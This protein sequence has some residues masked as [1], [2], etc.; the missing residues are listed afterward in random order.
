[1]SLYIIGLGLS[2]EHDVSL[3]GLRIIRDCDLVYLENYTGLV[4][5][6]IEKLEEFFQKKIRIANR[7]LVEESDEM[8]NNASCCDVAFLVMG[9]PF[10]ATTHYDLFMRAKK[11]NI[12]ACV[13]HNA[14]IITA[15]GETGLHLYKFGAIASMPILEKNFAPESFFDILKKNQKNGFHTLCLLDMKPEENKFLNIPQA[16]N[17]LLKINKKRKEK[18]F[19]EKTLIIGCARI[20]SEEQVIRAG[21]AKAISRID[22]GKPPYCMVIPGKLHF[23]EEEALNSFR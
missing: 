20:G 1:M 8:L 3:K 13:I 22:F 10:S 5:A 12:K 9:D 7:K 16:I 4:Q 18:V 19:S 2:E 17:M 6:P 23:S 15:I 14:S 21:D 11:K